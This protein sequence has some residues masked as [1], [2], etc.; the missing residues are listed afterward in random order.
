MAWHRKPGS[1]A[2]WHG[3][4]GQLKYLG[5]RDGQLAA[6]VAAWRLKAVRLKEGH[7]QPKENK[8]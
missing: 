4:S 3:D 5:G 8:A 1:A 6:I 7:H 2:G